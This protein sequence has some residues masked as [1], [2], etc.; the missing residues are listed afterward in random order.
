MENYLS[1]NEAYNVEGNCKECGKKFTT[2]ARKKD[3]DA[4]SI[5][6][7]LCRSLNIEIISS[8]PVRQILME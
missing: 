4:K 3:V 8:G 7:S 6:C 2:K 1:E 5:H